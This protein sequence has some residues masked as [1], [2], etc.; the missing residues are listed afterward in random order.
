MSKG[1]FGFAI[2]LVVLFMLV[3]VWSLLQ[4]DGISPAIDIGLEGTE[5]A[6]FS[7]GIGFI[8]RSLPFMIP[9]I[10]IIGFLLGGGPRR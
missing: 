5:S 7:G 2:M 10:L 4:S 8:L 6:A 3:W 1:V 9:L